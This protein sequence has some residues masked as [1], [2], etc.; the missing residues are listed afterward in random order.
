M[1]GLPGKVSLNTRGILEYAAG[2]ASL[3]SGGSREIHA[4]HLLA[5]LLMAPGTLGTPVARKRLERQ[6]IKLPAL[7]L[8]FREYIR[9]YASQDDPDEWN[10]ILGVGGVVPPSARTSASPFIVGPAGY[11]SEFCG[12]GG[13]GA[14]IDCLGVEALAQRLAEL[15]AL[16]ETK[17]PLAV[18]LFGSWGSGK[19]YFMNLIDR[20]IKK[21]ARE[22][23]EESVPSASEREN[24]VPPAATTE[25]PWCREIVSIYFNAWHYSDTNLWASLVTEVFDGLFGHLQPKKNEL[26]LMQSRLLDAGG[27]TA[28][29]EEEVNEAHEAVQKA[30]AALQTA[31][32]DSEGAHQA[33]RGLVDGLR[34]LLPLV[35]TTENERRIN[36]WLGVSAN[37]ATLSQLRVKRKELASLWGRTKDL[38][39]RAT[40]PEGRAGR[41]GWL[42]GALIVFAL[43]KLTAAYWPQLGHLLMRVRPWAQLTVAMVS[44]AITF[45]IP[46]VKEGLRVL[47]QMEAW[48]KQAE[49]AQEKLPKEPAVIAAQEKSVQ[50]EARVVEAEATLAA[51]RAREEKLRQSVDE[52]RPERRLSRFIEARARSSDYRGQ[53]GLVGLARRDFEEL[54]DIFADAKALQAKIRE[55]PGQAEGLKKLGASV[56]RIVL[57]VDDLDRCQPEKVVDVLQAIHLLLAFPLFGVVVGV[58]QRCLKQS[59]RMRFE[60]LVTPHQENDF[61]K[62]KKPSAN[63]KEFP[64]TPL[65]YLEKIFHIPFHLPVMEKNGFETLVERLTEPITPSV[66]EKSEN[67]ENQAESPTGSSA[68]GPNNVLST[69][70]SIDAPDSEARAG[71][72]QPSARVIGSVPLHRWER[73]SL[74]EY[75]PL[76]RTPRA[77]TRLLNTYRLVRA[78]VPAEEW[79]SFRGDEGGRREFRVAMLLLAVAA[80]YPAVARQWFELLRNLDSVTPP[81]TIQFPEASQVELKQFTNLYDENLRKVR[82]PLTKDL[83]VKWLDRVER[84]TF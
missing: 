37:V 2:I 76:I 50:A 45:T 4:R 56:D 47:G 46:A 24:S 72:S 15:L 78:G 84:F 83:L 20:H 58:D 49:A 57:F 34:T 19:S 1:E 28:R 30:A 16:R 68:S 23:L 51:A 10:E 39:H 52:L 61:R 29:A 32:A 27:A 26:A 40:A 12:L 66:S 59:L 7:C 17:L 35:N 43:V 8:E 75:H 65:D 69:G 74:K 33:V 25:S 53:L 48:Q 36:E 73:D 6:G 71:I 77:V 22:E 5:A 44:S 80:G 63:V 3:V 18:G 9:E 82:V 64:A 55:H 14:T 60:G 21:L 38:W 81:L 62:G 70:E 54:S 67:E 31:R 42:F 11:N 79:D 13:A 41:L